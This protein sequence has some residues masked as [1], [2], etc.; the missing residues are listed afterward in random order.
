MKRL[1]V[2]AL[3][4]V[5][6]VFEAGQVLG[7]PRRGERQGAPA[8]GRRGN[9]SKPEFTEV[10]PTCDTSC[11]SFTCTGPDEQPVLLSHCPVSVAYYLGLIVVC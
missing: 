2:C 9:C 5:L 10:C 7:R 11:Q 3:L 4:A 8:E 1:L 6:V